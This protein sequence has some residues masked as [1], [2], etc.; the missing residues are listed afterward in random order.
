[1]QTFYQWP[2]RMLLAGT[3]LYATFF[4]LCA[5]AGCLVAAPALAQPSFDPARGILLHG[6]VVTM[7]DAGTILQ[8]G[9]VLVRSGKIVAVWKGARP[10]GTPVDDAV[11]IDLGPGTLI[12]PGLIDLHDHPTFDMLHLRPAPSSHVQALE[13]RPLGTEPYANR[14]QMGSS[15]EHVRLVA[16]PSD[17][18]VSSIGLGLLPEVGKYAEVKAVFGGETAI[19]GGAASPAIDNILIRN[20]DQSNFGRDRIESRVPRIG[21]LGGTTLS[22]LLARMRQGLVDAWI[23]HLAEGVRD[24][25]RRPGDAFSSRAE[26]AT[27][28]SKGLLTDMT[29]IVHGNGLEPEDFAAMRTAPSIRLDGAGDGLGAKLVWSPLSNLLLYGQT[30]LVYHALAADVLVSLGTDWSPSGSR[31]LLDELKIADVALRDERLLGGDRDLV[32]AFSIAGKSGEEV[33]AA[34]RALDE[35]LVR[36]VTTNPAKA[37]RWQGEV[38]SIAVGKVADLLII[39]K[40]NHPSAEDLPNSPYRNL[41]DATE[42]DVN[43]VLVDGEPLAGDVALMAALKPG[44]HEVVTST[45]AGFQKAIDVTK[46][47]VVLGTETIAMIASLLRLGLEAMGGDHPPAGG[48]TA[49]DTNTYSYLKAHIPGAAQLTDSAFRDAL[50]SFFGL[51][52]NGRLNLERIEL[53]PVLI[54]DDDFYFHVIEGDLLAGTGLIADATPPFRL[55]PANFNQIQAQGNPF[56]AALYRDRYYGTPG[57]NAPRGAAVALRRDRDALNPPPHPWVSPNP[58]SSEGFLTFAT[59]SRGH[60]HV[61]LFDTHGRLV[62]NVLEAMDLDP[63]VHRARIDCL[64]EQSRPLE[65][66]IYFYRVEGPREVSCCRLLILR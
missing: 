57:M 17:L 33:E 56:A 54:E 59:K 40:P 16:N 30:A 55:Y 15:P 28:I 32:P 3:L 18:L 4:W 24:G 34:E 37:L 13:G 48:G 9:N 22:L 43:L 7:D 46:Q 44:D 23:V 50:V 47:G 31:N 8:R 49:D 53:A 39:T 63:G 42:A 60:V 20:V 51:D 2:R 27:L 65:P 52:P 29:V 5:A 14:Y 6:T 38:G 10:P 25:Q 64:D 66:G 26:F 62:R 21:A 36:M 19:Q 35:Q 61:S 58:L 12:F 1:M 45:S 41:I 11:V